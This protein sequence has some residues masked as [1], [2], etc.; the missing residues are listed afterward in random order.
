MRRYS[1][2]QPS[3]DPHTYSEGHWLDQNAKRQESRRLHFDFDALLR[4]AVESSPGAK[5]V[6][7]CEKREGGFNRVFMIRLDNDKTV[8]AR[9]PT[10]ETTPQGLSVSSEVATLRFGA[11]LVQHWSFALLIRLAVKRKTTV[12]VPTVL[13][14]GCTSDNPV[15]ARYMMMEEMPGVL[16]GHVWNNM[17]PSQ[18]L[19]CIK[20]IGY[21]TGQLCDIDFPYY[22]SLYLNTRNS[23]NALPLDETF[24]IGPLT[25]Q[26]HWEN[27]NP[28]MAP[29]GRGP[30]HDLQSYISDLV[31][32]SRAAA[33]GDV[34]YHELLDITEKT[35]HLITELEAVKE[36]ARP[37]LWHPDLHA[38]NIFVDAENP[39]VVTGIID[40]QSASIEPAFVF[41]S[42]TPD[43][44]REL[45]S[46]KS[47]SPDPETPQGKLIVDSQ[48]C[49]KIWTLML[50]I[51]PGYREAA[52][53]PTTITNFL[54]APSA[55][56]LRDS[57]S[58]HT[59]LTNLR[60][61]WDH[62]DLPGRSLYQPGA[63]EAGGM[64]E[65]RDEQVAKQELRDHLV[66]LLECDNDGW[67]ARD[68][69]EEVLPKYREEYRRFLMSQ[70]EDLKSEREKAAA[71]AK[72]DRM[73]PFDQR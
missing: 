58:L 63:Q 32:N 26:Q 68:R 34:A 23:P 52:A 43:F 48:F 27:S 61:R 20:S 16:L 44:A 8:V 4:L 15:G 55:G 1:H 5:G 59:L 35:L 66:K 46:L 31:A 54:A 69:W 24:A 3:F 73:W 9:L 41:A 38:R 6:V 72:A 17:T 28:E 71:M 30:W 33:K 13:A 62:F 22:G 53:L 12:P 19:D 25:A 37:I 64:A 51:C 36:A 50:R 67:V 56:W 45:L 39:T 18:H 65:M 21:L 49:A 10:Q 47:Q 70:V 14:W 7:G 11:T 40:W 42:D 2:F 57:A 60:D 29:T